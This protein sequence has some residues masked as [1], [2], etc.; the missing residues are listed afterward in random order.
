MSDDQ[1]MSDEQQTRRDAI[2]NKRDEDVLAVVF[3]AVAVVTIVLRLDS[4]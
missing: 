1:G 3:V 4:L 2:V